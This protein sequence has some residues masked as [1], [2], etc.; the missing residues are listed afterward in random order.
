[1]KKGFRSKME[2]VVTKRV[3]VVRGMNVRVALNLYIFN[4][5]RNLRTSASI[6]IDLT[7]GLH[8]SKASQTTF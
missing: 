7:D 4:L 1:M 5:E 8:K 3:V 6:L 2:V